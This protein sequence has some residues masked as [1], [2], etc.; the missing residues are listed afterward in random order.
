MIKGEVGVKSIKV[1]KYEI[2]ED[3]NNGVFKAL[4][5]GEEWRD[6]VGDKLILALFD[7]LQT[8]NGLLEEAQDVM[9][10]VHCYDTDTYRDISKHL[11]GE[12]D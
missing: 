8:A 4:R 7:K 11:R 5:H 10:N 1:D 9:S 3:I 2:I 6:L 12:E